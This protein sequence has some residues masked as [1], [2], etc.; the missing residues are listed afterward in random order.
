MTRK[1]ILASRS[2]QRKALL[3]S[4]DLPFEVIPA[5]INE[6]EIKDE[7]FAVRARNIALAKAKAV[8]TKHEGII[9][10]ADTFVVHESGRVL[11][12]PIN[13]EEAKKMLL[14]ESGTKLKVYTGFCYLDKENGIEHS[15][16][17]ITEVTFRKLYLE[18]IESYV[19]NMPVLTWSAAY[20]P[21]YHYGMSMIKSIS[22]S[23]TA[24]THGLPLEAL[25][26]L[27]KESGF[28]IRPNVQFFNQFSKK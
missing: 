12:K 24:F 23:M 21:A 19:T 8:S 9:I 28:S 26:P 20:S 18:E 16:T 7:D 5:D 17:F 3:S 27:L 13:L 6:K 15:E 22:G 25:V 11:E 14:L 1:I 10:A 4:L 2:L